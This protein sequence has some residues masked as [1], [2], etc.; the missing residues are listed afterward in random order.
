MDSLINPNR[1]LEVQDCF[2]L[3][4]DDETRGYNKP[5]MHDY[6]LTISDLNNYTCIICGHKKPN[7]QGVDYE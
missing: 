7:K 5:C 4:I 6:V 1:E 2:Q 3:W